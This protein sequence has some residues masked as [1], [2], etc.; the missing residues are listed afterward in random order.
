[1]PSAIRIPSGLIGKGTE[2]FTL[3]QEPYTIFGGQTYCFP[4]TPSCR[5]SLYADHMR[6]NPKGERAMEKMTG[7][8]D[9]MVKT[10]QWMMCR[11]GGMDNT[12]DIDENNNIQAAEYVPCS[13]RGTCPFEGEGCST[14]E[15]AEGVFLSKAEL[16][17]VRL[18]NHPEKII[19]DILFISTETVKNHIANSKKKAGIPSSKELVHWATINGII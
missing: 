16:A 18:C 5:V 3:N 9:L 19:A 11:F 6:A 13:K 12:P 7:S 15:V 2:S 17:V 1:M 4:T 14:I 10:K 8:K